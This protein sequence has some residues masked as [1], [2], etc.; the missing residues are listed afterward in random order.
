MTKFPKHLNC[1]TVLDPA[2]LD[3]L[4]PE[5][6]ALHVD[7]ILSDKTLTTLAAVDTARAAALAVLVRVRVGDCLMAH[8][9]SL[10][11]EIEVGYEKFISR[12]RV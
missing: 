12:Q 7:A 8:Y 3:S 2:H 4:L 6:L 5:D 11:L 9:E 1:L 10:R